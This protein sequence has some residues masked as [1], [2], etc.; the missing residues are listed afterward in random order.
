MQFRTMFFSFEI[1][2]YGTISKTRIPKDLD[3]E[4]WQSEIRSW[5][6]FKLNHL[7][8]VNERK[9]TKSFSEI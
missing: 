6:A 7:S 2:S 3:V 8:E 9:Q 4:V 1:S 5:L